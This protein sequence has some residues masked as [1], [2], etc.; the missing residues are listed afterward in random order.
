MFGND[1]P[2][3][4]VGYGEL[5]PLMLA[6]YWELSMLMGEEKESG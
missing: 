4:R 1:E 3:E 6:W 5:L 2:P